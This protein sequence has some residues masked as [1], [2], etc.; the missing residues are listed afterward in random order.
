LGTPI[1]TESYLL[2]SPCH[3]K[4]IGKRFAQLG[5]GSMDESTFTQKLYH[6]SVMQEIHHRPDYWRGYIRGSAPP[7]AVRALERVYIY[8]L[9]FP[10]GI[11][12]C[13]S[14]VSQTCERVFL[15]ILV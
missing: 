10:Y 9:A 8:L 1:K 12:K 15:T 11:N 6:A 7:L 2:G 3:L 13:R 5:S 14:S 4:I